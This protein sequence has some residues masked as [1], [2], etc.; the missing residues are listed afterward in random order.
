MPACFQIRNEMMHHFLA[1]P[2]I[3]PRQKCQIQENSREKYPT[4]KLDRGIGLL[5]R[6]R[7]TVFLTRHDLGDDCPNRLH[8][9]LSG[10]ATHDFHRRGYPAGLH[11]THCLAQFLNLGID[12]LSQLT[13]LLFLQ[14]SGL[15]ELLGCLESLVNGGDGFLIWG[16]IVRS[17]RQ[18]V[19]SLAGLGVL[20]S[21][22]QILNRLDGGIEFSDPGDCIQSR[23]PCEVARRDANDENRRHQN[24]EEANLVARFIE[25]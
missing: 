25:G 15:G 6:C 3:G 5:A 8:R 14:Q 24:E 16:E 18:E 1:D 20:N 22:A 12:R 7:A 11:E 4:A 2:I 21:G 9:P 13:H 19:S 17:V 23:S 10:I